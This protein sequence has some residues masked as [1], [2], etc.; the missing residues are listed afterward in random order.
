MRCPMD[1]CTYVWCKGCQQEIIPNEPEHSC[2]GTSEL[3][4]LVQE[5]GWKFCP[6][7]F[8]YPFL[9]VMTGVRDDIYASVQHTMRKD[10]WVQLSICESDVTRRK[11]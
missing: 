2:D 11:T 3:K 9:I 4:H 1:G 10:F 7:K 6:S 5:Q 8:T